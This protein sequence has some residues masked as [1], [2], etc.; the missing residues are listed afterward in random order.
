MSQALSSGGYVW[1]NVTGSD[2]FDVPIGVRIL[3]TQGKSIRIRNDDGEETTVAAN[4]VLKPMHATSARGVED[5]ITLADLQE[6]TILRNLHY[7][8]KQGLIYT[9][10]G[11]ILVAVN[12][13]QVLPI[14][15]SKEVALYKD[16]KLGELHPHIFAIGDSS[17]SDMM[18]FQQNQCI[19]IS[20]ESGAGKTES[21]KLILRYLA[22][23]SGKHS[24]IEQQILEANPI[25]E[26]FGNA[27]TVRNDNSSRFG[28]YIDIH[29]NSE[30]VIEGAQIEQYL[31][32]KSRIVSQNNGERNYH[33]FY[34][35]LA[36]LSHDERKSLDLGDASQYLYLTGGKSLTCDGR[37]DAAE[38]AD[39]RSAMKVLNFS[40]EETL[41]IIRLLATILYL[42]NV[43]YKGL[44][45]ANID[46][47]EIPDHSQV[48]KVAAILGVSKDLLVDALT[49]KTML[50]QGEKVVC[51]L[52]VEQAVE[53]RDA[54]VKGIYGQ[55]FINIV[56]KINSTIF[57]PKAKTKN[58]IGVLD[59]FGFENFDTN[60]FEQLCINYANENLQ[61]FFVQ[62]IFK[63]EQEEYTREDISWKHMSFVDNQ[64]I[65]DLIGVKPINI[66][67][68]IDEE[69]KFP[70]GTDETM[71]SKLHKTHEGNKHY[72]KPKSEKTQTFGLN[73]FAGTVFYAVKGFLEKNRDSFSTDLKQLVHIASNKFLKNL[74]AEELSVNQYDAKKR[75]TTLSAQFQKSLDVLM[76]TLSSCR[77]FFVR[78]IKPNSLKKPQVFDRSLCCRQ[79]R[80]SGM[81]ETA[82][83]RRAGYPIR[84]TFQ[85]FVERYRFLAPGTPHAHKTDCKA[86]SSKICQLALGKQDYQLG[87]TKVFLKDAHDTLLEQERE[88]VLSKSI[89]VLQRSVRT[90]VCRKRFLQLRS[91]TL[92][93]QKYWRGR[94]PR[95]QY[96]KMRQGH[97]RLQALLRSRRLKHTFM[98]IRSR[99]SKFQAYCRGYLV[100]KTLKEKS[101]FRK[102]RLQELL[103]QRK[104]EEADLKKAGHKNYKEIAEENYKKRLHELDKEVKGFAPESIA[105]VEHEPPDVDALFDFLDP[106]I[107][108][109]GHVL[110]STNLYGIMDTGVPD[111]EVIGLPQTEDSTENLSEFNF[112]KYAAMYFC[113]NVNYQYSRKPI[114]HSLLDLP[115]PA[116]QL[117]AKALWITILRFMGD[118]PEPRYATENS[119]N[120]PIMTKINKTL[121][122][123]FVNSKEYKDA[124]REIQR[125]EMA[126]QK[127]S[128][129][130]RRKLISMTLK[131]K[132]KLNENVRG[133]LQDES[134]VS[135]YTLWLEGRRT[136]NL[137]KI[138]FIIGH[139]ILR[140]E[141]R[142][143][144]YCQI[145]KQLTNNPTQ[146]SHAR[147]WIL[148]SLC[149]GCFPP[150]EQFVN[151]LKNFI[152]GGPRGYAPYCEGRLNR[153]FNNGSRTQPPCWVELQATKSGNP[154]VI[155]VT[156]MDGTVKKLTADSATTA[157]E[158]CHQLC[159][160]INLKDNFGFSLFIALFD[161][162]SSLG[163]KGDHVMDAISQCEQYAKEQGAQEKSAPW[164]LFFRKEIFTPWHNPAEDRV[165]TNLIYQ[166]VVRGAKFG[167]YRCDKESDIAMMAA[168][169]YYVE[170]GAN[171]DPRVLSNLLPNYIP[172]HFLK[173]G[174]DKGL[175]RW[176][177]LVADAFKKS[178]FAKE[179][180]PD[181]KVKEDIV[182]YAMTK[183][184]LL[185]SRFYETVK[186]S[187][188][189]MPKNNMI[190]AV[191]WTGIYFVDDEEQVLMELSYP[192]ITGVVYN[193]TNE[194]AVP[195]FSLSTIQGHDFMFQCV[196]AEDF[197]ELVSYMLDGLKKRS[198]YVIALQDYSPPVDG[199]SVLIL[200]KGDVIEL[201][202]G[203]LGES[204]MSGD[205]GEG[206]C[207]RTRMKGCF[208]VES[209][210]VLPAIKRPTS[211]ILALFKKEG[212]FGKQ[213]QQQINLTHT[214]RKLYTL[215]KY[216]SQHFRTNE[217][218]TGSSGQMLTLAKRSTQ[219]ELWKHSRE[220]LKKPLLQKLMEHEQL[221][222]DACAAFTAVL[223]YMG[224]L[225][226]GRT[227]ASTEYTD[228]IFSGPLKNDMLRDEIYCQIMK[229]LTENRNWLSEERGWELMWLA[230]GIAPCSQNL[231]KELTQFLRCRQHP[232]AQDS[233]NR[234]QRIVRTGQRK[235]PPH[236]VEV[237]AIQH[238]SMKIFHKIYFP[239][240]TDEAFEVDSSTRAR[241][242]CQNISERLDLRAVE[243]FSLI[244]KIRERAF[245]V[246][247]GEFFFDYVRLLTEWMKKTRPSRSAGGANYQYHIF[248]IKKLWLNTIPGKDKNADLIFYFPQ[249]APKYLRGYHK[250][251]KN[252]AIK[253]GALLYRTK[254]GDSKAD[255]QLV[256][257][258]LEELVPTNLLKIQSANDWK[259]SI[260]SAWAQNSGMKEDEAKV[261][262]L[263]YIHTW[264][265]FGSAFFDVKQTNDSSYPEVITVAINKRGVIIIHPQTK[266]ILAEHPFTHISN[267][268][269]GNTF[270]QV[271]IGNMVRGSKLLCETSL[272]Y[273]MDD[274]LTSYTSALHSSL[275]PG[276]TQ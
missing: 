16:R 190:L 140:P 143:E 253:I 274:L 19:V 65:L 168:Q 208:P 31:L 121:N 104:K 262:F 46:A 110:P 117:A 14:Y 201:G 261:A 211:D 249:E 51:N 204:V 224:D 250:V 96:Q 68:L 34:S 193:K 26:A 245:S 43:K 61:Q 166:Q 145:C 59:I 162:V 267:W 118:L 135:S 210:Y 157:E 242:L 159:D 55:L 58:S 100:R 155:D 93:L 124:E 122:R 80:Y 248:F 255:L 236:Q 28:K 171:L 82:K 151:Y 23:I 196:N 276:R 154:I 138:H 30:G 200:K 172:N 40:D 199:Q 225:P 194:G 219:E 205:W 271:S 269:S 81:M 246:P 214:R 105:D 72:L 4:L 8:Y 223:K 266:E 126:L 20:G 275:H 132:N 232:V 11:S 258:I 76:K 139:G 32:E 15:T 73:H 202:D 234:I 109:T 107:S 38:F 216:A 142:D 91:A 50:V 177:N 128:A 213:N 24:W 101:Q 244:V 7:R 6:H 39:I 212:A 44:V 264:P 74:F 45:I 173:S 78:C 189:E 112:R 125:E 71:L 3:S 10:T 149:I 97:L 33:I 203:I 88:R 87:H 108:D 35:M 130:E 79:L 263:Q 83:I 146:S 185:F 144:I 243:G 116:D 25:L 259:K 176:E 197:H 136:T 36:G 158:L 37:N 220:P 54:F 113:G 160:N 57:K 134:A 22:A 178:Y 77:P 209:V 230:T 89:L 226:T 217:T 21:T 47:A 141:L 52:S 270:F 239:D 257:Q 103:Q 62:H 5:M 191:S 273:K 147:G 229:Q 222:V 133:L 247:D 221:A 256:P 2:E 164:R 127:M 235:H 63:L 241:D 148:L 174:A 179:Q 48:Q 184:P 182:A 260:S 75:N 64:V 206:L 167:E 252:D 187:G 41:N 180:V 111:Q 153:T 9:Y 233:L 27:K 265:T 49:R 13:Y 84:H 98:S 67:S 170:S 215:A 251:T 114:R 123:N 165:A 254:F 12:P 29:F 169:H 99:I 272:G 150:S 85:E 161:K 115:L 268:S 56:Q 18:R 192:E 1:L 66:M 102:R 17:F 181:I 218:V 175:S 195:V 152:R 106:K 238:K 131:H 129:A 120:T 156:F 228:K 198:R 240:D 69:S 207:E 60:S 94:G 42:G 227:R 92:T 90:W 186:I 163:S 231:M 70:K 53:V 95:L 86:A 237:E 188:P 183:W 137:E 119:D